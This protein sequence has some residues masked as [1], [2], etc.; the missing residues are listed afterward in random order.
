MQNSYTALICNSNL[1]VPY[2]LSEVLEHGDNHYLIMSD[3]ENLVCFFSEMKLPNA[4]V[5]R[6]AQP[7]WSTLLHARRE[8]L[9]RTGKYNIRKVIF[10]HTEFGGIVNWFLQRISKHVEICYCNVFNN[11]PYPKAR[12][13]AAWKYWLVYRI[14]FGSDMDILQAPSRFCHSV[15]ERFYKK[16]GAT[17]VKIEVDQETINNRFR[18]CFPE[19]GS[20][21]KVVLLTG[22]TVA[23]G[24]VEKSEYIEK[25][26]ALIEALGIQNCVAKCHPRF[27]DVFSKE[28]ELPA[29][30]S[31]IPGNLVI[32][33]Y[34]VFIGNHSTLL[35]E[36]AIAGKLAISL[37][38]YYHPVNILQP[39]TFK[40]FLQDRL[41][42]RGTIHYPKTVDEITELIKNA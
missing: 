37:L 42:G 4:M 29:I 36:A 14:V 15:P 38:D 31:Y 33:N 25:T 41:G 12:G 18:Q 22:S 35:A 13:L 9:A 24:Y 11:L 10:F 16:I 19:I 39:S 8:I 21:A 32:G 23:M 34:D 40:T 28:L 27:N 2:V 26:D 1:F 5:L 3:V 20:E 17:P 7:T 6:Y 30:P